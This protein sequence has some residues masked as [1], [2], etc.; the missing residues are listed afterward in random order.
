MKVVFFENTDGDNLS[1]E[2]N[3]W[4]DSNPDIKIKEIKQ[5]ALPPDAIP[6]NPNSKRHQPD[7]DSYIVVSIWYEEP[8]KINSI[9]T[10]NSK[11]CKA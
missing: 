1:E 6:E 11:V 5:S 8:E 4:L 2:V 9:Q 3:S 7:S 10:T